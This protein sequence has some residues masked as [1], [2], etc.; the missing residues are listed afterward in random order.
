GPPA[1]DRAPTPAPPLQRDRRS[2]HGRPPPRARTPPCPPGAS[3]P[4]ATGADAPNLTVTVR[5]HAAGDRA[6]DPHPSRILAGRPARSHPIQ[7]RRSPGPPPIN[8][9]PPLQ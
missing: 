2:V 3:G 6:E 1:A 8:R 5:Q 7:A 4:L 9:P